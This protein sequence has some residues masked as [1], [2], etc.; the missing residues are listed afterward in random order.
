M[1]LVVFCKWE[2]LTTKEYITYV[3]QT[4]QSAGYVTRWLRVWSPLSVHCCALEQD[5][6]AQILNTGLAQKY[7]D[8]TEKIADWDIQYQLK[9]TLSAVRLKTITS[10]ICFSVVLIARAT[11][12]RNLTIM[13]LRLQMKYTNVFWITISIICKISNVWL[14]ISSIWWPWRFTWI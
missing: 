1:I 8:L 13:Q 9:R 2:I 10:W 12:K 3:L 4:W 11:I 6:L 14:D 7:L 5:N